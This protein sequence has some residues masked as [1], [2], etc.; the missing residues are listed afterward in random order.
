MRALLDRYVRSFLEQEQSRDAPEYRQDLGTFID[1]LLLRKGFR[2]VERTFRHD[3]A[4]RRG[5]RGERQWE[6]T[7]LP[8]KPMKTERCTATALCLSR[9]QSEVINGT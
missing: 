7:Y 1:W 2:V 9:A 4:A 3:G 6:P 8:S 5:A